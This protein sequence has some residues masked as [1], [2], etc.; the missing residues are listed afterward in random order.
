MPT[1][2]Y[3]TISTAGGAPERFEWRQSMSEAPLAAHPETGVPV[4]RVISGGLGHMS[5]SDR[6]L[7]EPGRGCGP[8]TCSCGRF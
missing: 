6:S 2:I 3:E 4:R 1:Y 5:A 7:P 8:A